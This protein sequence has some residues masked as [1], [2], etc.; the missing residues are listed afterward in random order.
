VIRARTWRLWTTAARRRSKKFVRRPVVEFRL[1]REEISRAV[2]MHVGEGVP[3]SDALG[4]Q[5]LANVVFD[6]A[7]M[8]VLAALTQHLDEARGDVLG[9]ASHD[10]NQP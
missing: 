6:S 9:T 4:A 10:L 8:V 3:P 7:L 2:L 1:L 5:L